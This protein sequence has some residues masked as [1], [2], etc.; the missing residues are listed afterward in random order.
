MGGAKG[1]SPLAGYVFAILLAVIVI[2]GVS[3]LAYSFYRTL[4]E[5]EVKRELTQAAAQASSKITEIYS[6]SKAS[7]ASPQNS[8]AILLADANL[9]LPATVASKKYQLTL[10]SAN[11]VASLILNVTVN[12]QNA[13]TTK[14]PQTGKI[15]AET[16]EDPFV[17]IDYEIPSI[18][19]DLQGRS[20]SPTNATLR[21]YRYNPN[22][23]VIDTILLG[24]Y[25]L[26]GQ[27]TIIS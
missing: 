13:S 26:V 17:K 22:G 11:Q 24:D 3:A 15:V 4:L 10:L 20:D 25:T 21:Y 6:L 2:A 12:N 16:T 18:D 8:T 23:T 1:I 9:N 14:L 27:V 5:D 7:K 19:V